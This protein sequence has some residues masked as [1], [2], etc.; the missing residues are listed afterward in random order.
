MKKIWFEVPWLSS[1]FILIGIGAA[2]LSKDAREAQVGLWMAGVSAALLLVFFT[3]LGIQQW[4]RST[5]DGSS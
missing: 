1:L 5:E 3:L 4:W 2:L